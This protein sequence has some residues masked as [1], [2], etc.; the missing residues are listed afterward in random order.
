MQGDVGH[1]DTLRLIWK[2]KDYIY[3]PPLWHKHAWALSFTPNVLPKWNWNSC[4]INT[5]MT[6]ITKD[7][8]MN[9]YPFLI[10]Y[11]TF[12]LS[13][14]HDPPKHFFCYNWNHKEAC[15]KTHA[16][17]LIISLTVFFLLFKTKISTKS[18][19]KKTQPSIGLDTIHTSPMVTTSQSFSKFFHQFFLTTQS[20]IP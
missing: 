4:S 5:T 12:F 17:E 9:T 1:S 13:P 8:K 20:S 2:A 18:I 19:T 14:S 3:N 11:N 7:K 15:W 10:S 6:N 16:F